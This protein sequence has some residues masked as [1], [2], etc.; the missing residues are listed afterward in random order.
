MKYT[1][2]L[3]TCALVIFFFG[4]SISAKTN[5]PAELAPKKIDINNIQKKFPAVPF[6]HFKHASKKGLNIPCTTCHHKSKGTNVQTTCTDCHS[7]HRNGKFLDV[8]GAFHKRCI[9]CHNKENKKA[10]KV[11]APNTCDGCHIRKK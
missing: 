1:R 10:K 6:D 8:K 11:I 4:T 3:L 9:A 2:Y 7:A 5:D